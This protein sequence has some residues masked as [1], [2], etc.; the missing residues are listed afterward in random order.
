MKVRSVIIDSLNLDPTS[1]D[2]G[3][4]SEYIQKVLAQ[5]R[6]PIVL[7]NEQGD[8]LLRKIPKLLD[9]DL[10]YSQKSEN[11]YE[12]L[13]AGLHGA[14]TCAFY[15]P[16]HQKYGEESTWL[17]LEKHLLQLPYLNTT[18]ILIPKED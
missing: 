18:H 2:V 5:R 6:N 11:K 4:L 16:L 7:I 8:D 17:N 10:V 1:S 14:G 12:G 15:L 9:S 13:L 3:K